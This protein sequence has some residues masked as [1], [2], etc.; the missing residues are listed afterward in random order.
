MKS[1]ILFTVVALAGSLMVAK[2]A[3]A[4]LLAYEGFNY[5]TGVINGATAAGGIGFDS[6]GWVD[7]GGGGEATITSGSVTP[8]GSALTTSGNNVYSYI[9]RLGRYLDTNTFADYRDGNGNIGKDNTTLYMSF[10]MKSTNL[11]SFYELELHRDG[12][13]DGTRIGGIGNDTTGTNVNLRSNVTS[14]STYDSGTYSKIAAATTDASLYVAKFDF[15]SGS[16]KVTVY[17]NPTLGTEPTT[18]ALVKT[19]AGDMSFDALSL[20]S[21]NGGVFYADEIRLG[22]TFASVTP[23]SVP[24]PSTVGLLVTGL[25]GLLAYAW[26]KRK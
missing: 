24:E 4:G 6:T 15:L 8:S 25:F 18:A 23:S 7:Q 19:D 1:R 17:A 9:R 5:S 11:G 14:P 22:T 26:R 12:L 10:V 13:A 20:A 16:D 21:F 2:D 3:F